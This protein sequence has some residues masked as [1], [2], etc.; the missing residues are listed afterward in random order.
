MAAKKQMTK[1]TSSSIQ[2][3]K[4][5]RLLE[6]LRE[7]ILSTRSQVAQ[8]VN[9]ALTALYWQIGSRIRR[10]IL[11]EQRAEYGA[12]IVSAL[13][14]QL[15]TEFGRGFAEKSLRHMLR[16]VEAFPDFEI[17]SA[18]MRQL[19]WTHFKSLIY[20]DD[21][22][23]RDFYAE[24]CRYERWSTRTLQDRIR[25]MLYERT[26]ISKKPEKLIEKE[27]RDLRE[28]GA[29]TPDLVFRDPYFLDFLGLRD[30]YSEKDLEAAILREMESF[31]LELGNGFAF[32][33][34]QKRITLDGDDYYI[35]LLFYHRRLRRLVMIELKIGD[36]KP[37]DKGQV[38]LYLRWLDRH[39]RQTGEDDPIAL[40]LCA[41]KKRETVKY[42]NLG[43]SGIHVAEY[44]TE[45]PSRELLAKRLHEAVKLARLRLDS[46]AGNLKR[47]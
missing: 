22:L 42:L 30:T 33:A 12:E 45:L 43:A 17:V 14:R 41:G 2:P 11:K 3:V 9:A 4:P 8:A 10:E 18:L 40:I 1:A 28:E 13:G 19:S 36:F 32:V 26:A 27:L 31:L 38:E 47:D 29:L 25:S 44:L 46:E 16:F 39:E 23:K 37:A 24:M 7:L 6:E 21:P 34:R 15:E 5:G 35:D 20:L